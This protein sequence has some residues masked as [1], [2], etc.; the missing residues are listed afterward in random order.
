MMKI[1]VLIMIVL[2]LLALSFA[3]CTTGSIAYKKI[4]PSDVLITQDNFNIAYSFYP[5]ENSRQGVVLL[6]MLGKNRNSWNLFAKNLQKEGFSV[7]SVDLR[8]HGESDGV[9]KSFTP[10]DFNDMVLD[11]KAAGEFLEKR[12]INSVYIMGASIG[13]NIALKYSLIDAIKKVVLLS[14]GMNYRG[15][16]ISQDIKNVKASA[17]IVASEEDEYSAETGRQ[18]HKNLKVENEFVLLSNAGHGT[19]MLVFPELSSRII[20]WLKR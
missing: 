16:D 8:G 7:I 19:D 2:A 9:L 3:S 17:M 5:S 20:E 13:A 12:G 15:V 1:E 4:K 6:H 10:K 14:P 18:M 11:V